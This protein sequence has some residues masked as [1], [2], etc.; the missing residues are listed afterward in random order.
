[1]R[2]AELY[3][4]QLELEC[5]RLLSSGRLEEVP[6]DNP[7]GLA[8]ISVVRFIDGSGEAIR[9]RVDADAEVAAIAGRL[10][11]AD[12]LEAGDPG[13]SVGV[14]ITRHFSGRTGI[15]G[16]RSDVG[17]FP[18]AEPDEDAWVVKVDGAVV[19]R[20]FS[21]RENSRA[22]ELSVETAPGY[23]RQGHARQV[24]A[25]W[26][27]SIV[28]SGRIAFYSY[29][30]ANTASAALARSLRVEPKFDVGSFDL[31]PPP[32]ARSRTRTPPNIV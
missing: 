31:G 30:F 20:A 32:N 25:A 11:V 6:C 17:A 23:R 1:M 24:A 18:A 2:A 22:A 16:Q 3:E 26:A 15:V 12:L 8:L 19:A 21:A 13:A 10:S 29:D 27:N 7:D 5:K 14:D 9:L 28:S 4:L